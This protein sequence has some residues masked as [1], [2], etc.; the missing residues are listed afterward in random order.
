VWRFIEH[1]SFLHH[2]AEKPVAV[3]GA[4]FP[5]DLPWRADHEVQFERFLER[6]GNPDCLFD[7]VSGRHDHQE[8][9]IALGVR[10]AI[11]VGAEEDDLLRMEPLGNPP[12][13]A[14]DRRKR[15]VRR[16]IAVWLHVPDRSG[17][18]PGHDPVV[19]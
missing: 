14:A 19:P 15:D 12:G 9:D 2:L 6:A 17:S 10:P 1:L 8:V 11:G 5:I 3:V 18:F 7:H 13:E 4:N 16:R